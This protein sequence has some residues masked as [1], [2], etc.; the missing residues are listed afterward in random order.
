MCDSSIL[1][2]SSMCYDMVCCM[3]HSYVCDV[4]SC[5][6][7]S[8]AALAANENDIAIAD[9]TKPGDNDISVVSASRSALVD[10]RAMSLDTDGSHIVNLYEDLMVEPA[11]AAYKTDVKTTVLVGD[12]LI[13]AGMGG[14]TI[15]TCVSCTSTMVGT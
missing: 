8:G 6:A 9:E 4:S 15:K 14:T 5:S 10:S 12:L 1:S 13:L 7:E 3:L 11:F 2:A